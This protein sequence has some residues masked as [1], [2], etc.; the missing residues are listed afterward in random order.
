MNQKKINLIVGISLVIIVGSPKLLTSP[1]W[2]DWM[3]IETKTRPL[4]DTIGGLTSPIV[5]LLSAFLLY[6][7]LIK[8][9]DAN[10]K[11][12]EQLLDQKNAE[13]NQREREN[14]LDDINSLRDDIND[15]YNRINENGRKI[16]NRTND[17][18]S[19]NIELSKEI[20]E[21][22]LFR[23]IKIIISSV[24]SMVNEIETSKLLTD[25]DKKKLLS[26]LFRLY[27]TKASD[28]FLLTMKTANSSEKHKAT[29]NCEYHQSMLDEFHTKL[30][31]AYALK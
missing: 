13:M 15:I 29:F 30:Y 17:L 8:Q 21:S 19:Y 24:H 5:N 25:E 2:C 11:Q 27:A 6:V 31:S 12:D 22:A 14:F 18:L 28:D 9:I 23:S 1:A 4:G 20:P 7:T 3:Q 26:K 16:F 10:K